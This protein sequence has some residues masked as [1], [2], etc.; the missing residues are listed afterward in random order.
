MVD[1]FFNY[2]CDMEKTTGTD[3]FKDF[4]QM[5]KRNIMRLLKL[6]FR[7]L[8]ERAE[9]IAEEHGF[10]DFKSNYIG[11]VAN[12]GP[13]GTTSSE[14]ASKLCVTKQAISKMTKE[15]EAH[16]YIVFK[17]HETDGRASVIQLTEKG[18]RL[19][20]ASLLISDVLKKEMVE[21]AGEADVEH[22]ID[23]LRLLVDHAE[24]KWGLS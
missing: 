8:G 17:A 22:L 13:D 10:P 7:Y 3:I 9:E 18:E 6:W 2:L 5:K 19:L 16:G 24:K 1:Y 20:A 23:T 21:L 14:L 15:I 12:L 11:F 4:Q